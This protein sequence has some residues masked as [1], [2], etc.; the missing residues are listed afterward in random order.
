M[1]AD[2]FADRN[3]LIAYAVKANSNLGVIATL[4]AE[5]AGADVVSGGEMAKALAAGIPASKIVF[6]GVG[7]TK[8]EMR[9]N[10][11]FYF[12]RIIS[13]KAKD[14]AQKWYDEAVQEIDK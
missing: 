14:I 8:E 3:V 4:A 6:S 5:G 12:S 2:A 1:L 9:K 10:M 7:K 13:K 11:N